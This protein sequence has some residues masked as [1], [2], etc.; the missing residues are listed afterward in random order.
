MEDI[1][2]DI[3]EKEWISEFHGMELDPIADD[4]KRGN[5]NGILFYSQFLYLKHIQGDLT[6][7]DIAKFQ[8]IT[9]NLRSYDKDGKKIMGLYDRGAGESLWADKERIRTISHDNLS[10]IAGF[11][12]LFK[13]EGLSEHKKVAAHGRKNFWRFDNVYP[14]NPRWGRIMH[15][16]DIIYWSYLAGRWWAKIAIFWVMIEAIISC[17]EAEEDRP[18][19]HEKV[20]HFFK[21]GKWLPKSH[22]VIPTSGKL[23]VFARFYPIRD[24]FVVKLTWRICSWLVEKNFGSWQNVFHIYYKNP[25]N[26]IRKRLD[27]I[28]E[29]NKRIF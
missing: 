6:H 14:E 20:I 28:V 9:E 10:A 29:K 26:P 2:M 15:P 13:D 18:R 11:S 23:M 1:N 16:R 19:I 5:E 27:K 21:T 7:A 4:S 8:I 12:Y 22:T 24:K 17:A 25:N 3:N